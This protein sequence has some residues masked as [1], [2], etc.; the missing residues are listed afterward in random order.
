[1]AELAQVFQEADAKSGPNVQ[2]FIR[3]N[4]LWKKKAEGAWRSW[5][6]QL[7]NTKCPTVKKRGERRKKGNVVAEQS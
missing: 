6:I 4:V 2:K 1:M 3:E 5:E 7:T